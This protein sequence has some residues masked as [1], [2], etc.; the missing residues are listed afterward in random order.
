M[1]NKEMEMLKKAMDNMSKEEQ[2]RLMLVLQEFQK[3]DDKH[4]K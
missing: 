1:S 3:I 4:N 2:I